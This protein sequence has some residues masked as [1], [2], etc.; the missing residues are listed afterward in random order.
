MGTI[1]TGWGRTSQSTTLSFQTPTFKMQSL[2]L[3]LLTALTVAVAAQDSCVTITTLA[4]T[5][6]IPQC[7]QSDCTATSTITL[8]CG[9]ASIYTAFECGAP[10]NTNDCASTLYTTFYIPCATSVSASTTTTE[11]SF[12]TN[13]AARS[14]LVDG[15]L[16]AGFIAALFGI[17]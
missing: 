8:S 5:C 10:C 6:K 2:P 17:L 16:V 3:A 15:G 9:C 11:T 7:T 13:V 12:T 1:L 4:P 14:A